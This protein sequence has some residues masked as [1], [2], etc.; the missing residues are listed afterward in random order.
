MRNIRIYFTFLLAVALTFTACKPNKEKELQKIKEL[1]ARILGDQPNN[2][3]GVGAYNLQTAYTGFYQNFPDAEE[4]PELIFKAADM[5]VNLRWSKQAIDFLNIIINEYPKFAKAP[6]ALFM[7]A[8]VY[9]HLVDDDAKAGELY[10]A[11]IDQYP[12]HVF[13]RDA[14]ASIRILGKSDEEIIREFEQRQM[15]D[16]TAKI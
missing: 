4:T 12:D 9:D 5:C 13:V 14:E 2:I 1:E 8:F 7:L 15:S 10:R 3:D 11:F 6:D 16:T